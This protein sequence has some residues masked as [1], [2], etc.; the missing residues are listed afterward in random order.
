MPLILAGGLT[1][2]NV[3][4]AISVTHPFAVDVASG[5]EGVSGGQDPQLM[6]AF[7]EAARAVSG[8][9]RAVAR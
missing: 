1:S 2:A 5:V 7:A 9:P 4:E 3:A 8:D 6:A